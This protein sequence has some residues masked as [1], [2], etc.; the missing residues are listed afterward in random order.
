MKEFIPKLLNIISFACA[1]KLCCPW[2]LSCSLPVITVILHSWPQ[3]IF[4]PHSGSHLDIC[5]W[6][7]G[8]I[9]DV[10]GRR[11]PLLSVHYREQT[12]FCKLT[13]SA[14]YQTQTEA[15]RLLPLQITELW[16]TCLWDHSL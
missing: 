16:K 11:H 2:L 15:I 1:E 13:S 9:G 8:D 5:L 14:K 7:S 6:I 12:V 4:T 3:L 10:S